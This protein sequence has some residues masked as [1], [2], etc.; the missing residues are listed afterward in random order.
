[1]YQQR[2]KLD[3]EMQELKADKTAL[4]ELER[5]RA[6]K[7]VSVE[8]LMVTADAP[9][10]QMLLAREQMKIQADLEK[11]KSSE[12]TRQVTGQTQTEQ[13]VAEMKAAHAEAAK[14]EQSLLYQQMLKDQQANA[15][16]LAQ[17]YR[18]G[19]QG[20]QNISQTGF[21]AMGQM[22]HGGMF[23]PP[24]GMPGPGYGPFPQ[25]PYGQV[26]PPYPYGQPPAPYPPAGPYSPPPQAAPPQG[27]APVVVCAKCRAENPKTARFC[28]NCG[29]EL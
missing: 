18:E 17:A 13:K 12:Q 16:R 29:G 25:P 22:G 26:P 20:Q 15:E 24:G 10:A 6:L 8:T 5:L 11:H 28:S 1:M 2:Q 27:P 7:D 3:A 23:L 9:H 21:S 19:M 14:M 4:R